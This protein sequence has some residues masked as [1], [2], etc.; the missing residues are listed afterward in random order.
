MRYA[1]LS[2]GRRGKVGGDHA[3]YL[4]VYGKVG[5]LLFILFGRFS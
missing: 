4:N 5:F 2:Y 1:L 3:R